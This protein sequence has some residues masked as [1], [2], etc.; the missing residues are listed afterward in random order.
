MFNLGGPL[1]RLESPNKDHMSRLNLL[2]KLDYLTNIDHQTSL[3]NPIGLYYL[4]RSSL[5]N[6]NVE[7]LNQ[8]KAP[9]LARSPIRL[10]HKIGLVPLNHCISLN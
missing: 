9:D 7:Y 1:D 8:A 4:T 5:S 3:D 10:N 6:S 2:T